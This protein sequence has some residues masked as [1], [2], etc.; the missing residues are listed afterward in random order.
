[1][2]IGSTPPFFTRSISS[3]ASSM[4]VR[5]AAKSVSNT[6][7]KPSLRSAA[8]ILPSQGEPIGRPNSSPIAARTAGAVWTSTTLSGSDSASNTSAV[9]SFSRSAPVGQTLMH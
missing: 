7:S 6:L 8:T 4:M 1:M 2:I 5:S 3:L 9:L